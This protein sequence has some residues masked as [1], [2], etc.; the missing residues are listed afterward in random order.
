MNYFHPLFSSHWICRGPYAA[1]QQHS[2]QW[3]KSVRRHVFIASS[4]LLFQSLLSTHTAGSPSRAFLSNINYFFLLINTFRRMVC[5][6]N[7]TDTVLLSS[8]AV[9]WESNWIKPTKDSALLLLFSIFT[10]L[11]LWDPSRFSSIVR[12]MLNCTLYSNMARRLLVKRFSFRDKTYCH[13]FY[14]IQPDFETP[15]SHPSLIL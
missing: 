13:L 9:L 6:R 12:S 10:V 3:F 4:S 2:L 15:H 8:V 5:I 11:L 14:R 7:A 1:L